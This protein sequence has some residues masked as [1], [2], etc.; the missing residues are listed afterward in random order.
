MHFD[1]LLPYVGEFGR[2]QKILFLLMMPFSFFLA[3]VYSTQIF[4]TLVPEQHWCR[5]PEL[6][7]LTVAERLHLAIPTE[8]SKHSKCFMYDV[9]FTEAILNGT[10][11]GDPLWPKKPCSYGWEFN[12]SVIPYTTIASELEWV[13]DDSN[14]PVISQSIFFCGAICGA[15]LFGWIAD[16]Y[17]RIPAMV[18][19][20]MLAGLAGIA[21]A[22][23]N[24]FWMFTLCRFIVGFAFDNCFT[25]MYILALE[26]VGPS[27]RTF[28]ANM[29]I[30]LFFTAGMCSMPLLALWINDWRLLA[31]ATS[32]P[33]LSTVLVPWIIPESARWLVSKGKTEEAIFILKK[34]ERMNKKNIKPQIYQDF[35]VTCQKVQEEEES[36]KKYSVLDLFR[37]PR[38]RRITILLILIY[39]SI[40][41]LFDGYVRNIESIGLDPFIG[42]GLAASTELPAS[43]LVTLILDR[44]GRRWLGFGTM[45]L[46]GLCSVIAVFIPTGLATTIVIISGRFFVNFSFNIGMQYAAELL[47]TVVRGQGVSFIHLTGYIA[48]IMSPIIVHLGV[49]SPI[50]PL[51]ILGFCGIGGGLLTLFLPETLGEQL[52]Q[53]LDDGEQFGLES[54]N[55]SF[56][57][58]WKV[59]FLR[60]VSRA[61]FLML[62]ADN[63]IF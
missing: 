29:S 21:T 32:V 5:I 55:V 60:V 38:L 9:N 20:N 28:V 10:K 33:M 34:F 39:M 47:P 57:M 14:K 40:S 8:N 11:S 58:H 23:S 44:W 22:F 1:D 16:R 2:Y 50:L 17:G 6:E 25:I 43:T 61:I 63:L 19:S 26:Y 36:F 37:T 48:T 54:K 42:F 51:L 4:I 53:S 62:L 52:P 12:H 18:G 49:V 31:I 59:K 7:N 13:C 15:I 30:A 41:L 3:Y 46:S 56:S 24:S 35:R 45:F 27:K